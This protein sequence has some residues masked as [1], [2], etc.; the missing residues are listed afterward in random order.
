MAL[1]FSLSKSKKAT[2]SSVLMDDVRLQGLMHCTVFC[3]NRLVQYVQSRCIGK[4]DKDAADNTA[5]ERAT[6]VVDCQAAAVMCRRWRKSSLTQTLLHRSNHVPKRSLISI[7][8]RF[9]RRRFCN[10]SQQ[11]RYTFNATGKI[12]W[13]DGHCFYRMH[14]AGHKGNVYV[15]I[16]IKHI[17]C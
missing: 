9:I 10:Q 17:V 11:L 3:L 15:G 1:L 7:R 5:Y 14:T 6:S 2:A 8:H 13:I 16:I 12:L 4:Q